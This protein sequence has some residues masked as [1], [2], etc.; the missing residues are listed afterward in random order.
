MIKKLWYFIIS[1]FF[2]QLGDFMKIKYADIISSSKVIDKKFNFTFVEKDGFK[3]YVGISY[4]TKVSAPKFITT[5]NERYLILDTDYIWM[6]YFGEKDEYA[7]TVMY[8]KNGEIVQWYVDICEGNFLDSRGI[9]YFRDMYLDI[10]LLPSGKI[11]ILDEDELKD[12][13]D[14]GEISKEQFNKAYN[15]MYKVKE[16]IQKGINPTINLSKKHLKEMM[17]LI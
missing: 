11:A 8:D 5:L 6:Q 12:A 17:R 7:T 2:I 10:V 13:L 1:R 16:E 3:G 4:F 15:V 14:Q 9:P